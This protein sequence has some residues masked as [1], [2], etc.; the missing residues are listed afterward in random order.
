MVMQVSSIPLQAQLDQWEHMSRFGINVPKY[1]LVHD[2]GSFED[3]FQNWVEKE[4]LDKLNMWKFERDEDE[5]RQQ[6]P[7][8]IQKL[9][10]GITKEDLRENYYLATPYIEPN[11][12]ILT[13]WVKSPPVDNPFIIKY[14]L[15]TDHRIPYEDDEDSPCEI[16]QFDHRES[17]PHPNPF[18]GDVRRIACGFPYSGCRMTWSVTK[19]RIG[20]NNSN[21]CFHD[22]QIDEDF[23]RD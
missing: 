4:D 14:G 17:I 3:L 12:F 5:A 21:L 23:V 16:L 6:M 10:S 11:E 7:T 1:F 2:E 13:G 15:R 20:K 22:Y 8:D 9:Y 19:N 18:V